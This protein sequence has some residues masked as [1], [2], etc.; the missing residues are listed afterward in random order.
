MREVRNCVVAVTGAAGFMAHHLL[1]HLIDDRGCE[2]V[3]IDNLCAGR[4]DFVHK[5]ANFVHHDL[6]G[7]EDRLRNIFEKN[8]VKYVFAL[9]AHP[10]VPDSYVRPIYVF[11]TNATAALRTMNAAQ[12]AGVEAILQVSSAEIYGEGAVH[13]RPMDE[14]ALVKPH[15]T[16][17]AAKAA[18]DFIVQVRWREAKTPAIALRQFN[19]LGELDLLHPYV[20]P[21]I[22]RQ[23]IPQ[24]SN[25]HATVRL[26]NNSQ[27]DFLYVGDAV[28]A[29]VLLLEKGKFGEVYN[30]GSGESV[31]IYDLAKQIGD[32]MRFPH[33]EV[34]PDDARRRK[35]ELWSLRGD[36]AKLNNATGWFPKVPFQ[37]AL[38]RTVESIIENQDKF[39]W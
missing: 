34:V 29:M 33:V 20:V 7:S 9:A 16:Y 15:S 36:F 21:E 25:L 27:R 1:K 2:V 30:S 17:S 10:Y 38:R 32:I 13:D 12:E 22:V 24:D 5:K 18:I 23:L 39:A 4:R 11:E 35:W 31:Y 19:V 14:D 26:G 37:E 6:L 3:A 8:K 28:E